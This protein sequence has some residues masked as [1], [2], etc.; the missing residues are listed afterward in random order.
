MSAKVSLLARF[1][2]LDRAL[3]AA[4]FPPTSPWWRRELERFLRS[5]RRRWVIRAGRRAGKSS[6]LCR[7]AVAV[8]LLYQLVARPEDLYSLVVQRGL[9]G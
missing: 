3:V 9:G 6:T 5:G 7:L 4:G 1:D 8:A 2:A